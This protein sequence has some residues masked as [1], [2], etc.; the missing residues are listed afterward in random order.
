MFINNP[1]QQS[2]GLDIGDT[3]IKLVRLEKKWHWKNGYY[4]NV[5]E[6][7]QISIPIGCIVAGEII[8]PELLQEKIK[9]LLHKHKN[10]PTLKAPWVVVNLPV[11][12]SFLKLIYINSP[13][14]EISSETIKFEVSKHLPIDTQDVS[15]D[16]QIINNGLTS[17]NN[18]AI[19]IGAV[20]NDIIDQYK[21]ILNQ[22]GLSVLAM[23]LEDIAIARTMITAEKSY[24]NEARAILDLGGS[25]SSIIIYD[26]GVIQFSAHINFSGDL[27]DSAIIQKFKIE[28]PD[29]TQLKIKNGLNFNK[30][31]PEYLKLM[32]EITKQLSDSIK[33]VLVFYETHFN[34]PNPVTHITMSGGLSAMKNLDKFLSKELDI[35][36]KPGNAWKNLFNKENNDINSGLSFTTAIGLALRATQWPIDHK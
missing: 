11:A 32:T 10:S 26:K 31:Y 7:R 22:S 13:A 35:D 36:S 30:H 17:S 15:I 14:S 6:I 4:F 28:R 19:L 34:K 9:L 5:D 12:K 27:L 25:R 18:T 1:F 33:K 23:E 24:Q 3:S 20:P 8:Q 16:W 29:A 2:F 21:N